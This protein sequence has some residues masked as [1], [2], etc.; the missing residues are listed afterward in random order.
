MSKTYRSD[1]SIYLLL[2]LAIK[3]VKCIEFFSNLMFFQFELK[4]RNNLGHMWGSNTN[5]KK[6]Q[7]FVFFEKF[8]KSEIGFFYFGAIA[9]SINANKATPN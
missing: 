4:N 1:I 6:I 7:H 5:T 8:A 2:T 9:H 3:K